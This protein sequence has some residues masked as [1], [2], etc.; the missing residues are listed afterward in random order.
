MTLRVYQLNDHEVKL[1]EALNKNRKNVLMIIC[2]HGQSGP[3]LGMDD[4]ESP[5]FAPYMNALTAQ[6]DP[7]RIVEI[8]IEE[9]P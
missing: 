4:L 7:A 2:E 6:M 1:I 9:A 5:T 3:V 8:E